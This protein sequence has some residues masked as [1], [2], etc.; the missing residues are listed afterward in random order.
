M[1]TTV[2]N[3]WGQGKVKTVRFDEKHLTSFSGAKPFVAYLKKVGLPAFC[4]GPLGL[5]KGVRHYTISQLMLL[6]VTAI[7]VGVERLS[8]VR[9][10]AGDAV[11]SRVLALPRMPVHKTLFG[12]L[13]RFDESA[14]ERLSLFSRTYVLRHLRKSQ[15][16]SLFVDFDSTVVTVYG[17]QEGAAVGY[18][19]T[20]L[21]LEAFFS[22]TRKVS[23]FRTV[24]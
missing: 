16:K 20:L 3:L 19:P 1:N 8:Q 4:D 5:V 10:F 18:N 2:A 23:V 24:F 6:M 9:L 15:R 21:Q 13:R 11:V 7:V 14:S 17:S 22:K 12:L